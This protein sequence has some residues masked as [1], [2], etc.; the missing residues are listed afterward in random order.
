MPSKLRR[1]FPEMKMRALCVGLILLVFSTAA[2]AQ[3]NWVTQFLNRYKPPKLDPSAAVVPQIS[4]QPWQPMV[5]QG[6]LP[7][8]VNDVIRLMLSSNLDVTVN[9]FSP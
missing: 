9:R 3:S 4:F 1:E 2:S 5:Q 6:V 7:I 8:T